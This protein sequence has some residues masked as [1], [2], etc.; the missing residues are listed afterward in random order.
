M[1]CT[2]KAASDYPGRR[3]KNAILDPLE[4]EINSSAR[5]AKVVMRPLHKIPA[6]ITN[7]ANVRCDANFHAAADL[8][9]SL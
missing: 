7:P 1:I 8:A 5:H 4:R 3:F 6:E 9:D 2:K